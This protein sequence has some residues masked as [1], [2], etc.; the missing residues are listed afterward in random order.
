MNDVKSM[1]IVRFVL[2]E[3]LFL[4]IALLVYKCQIDD[5]FAKSINAGLKWAHKQNGEYELSAEKDSLLQ[6]IELEVP[7]LK[8]IRLSGRAENV[9]PDT[10]LDISFGGSNSQTEISIPVLGTFGESEEDLKIKFDESIGTSGKY[11]LSVR[12]RNPGSTKVFLV[13][14]SKPGIAVSFNQNPDDKTNVITGISYGQ[15]GKLSGL[16]FN[17]VCLLFLLVGY[18]CLGLEKKSMYQLFPIGMVILGICFQIIIPIG[19]APDESWHMDTA[20]KYS[21]MLLGIHDDTYLGTIHKRRCDVILADMLG[22]DVETGSYYQ[23]MQG[24]FKPADETDLIEVVYY[25]TSNQVPG[26]V[27]LPMALG[28]TI[29]RLLG[30][31][32]VTVYV[33][34]R[35]LAFAVYAALMYSAILLMPFGKN[36]LTLV[37]MLPI[38]LQ[39]GGSASYDSVIIGIGSVF[40]AM[41]LRSFDENYKAALWEKIVFV[42]TGLMLLMSKG[43]VYAPIVVLG[44]YFFFIRDNYSKLDNKKKTI[45]WIALSAFTI[46]MGI[47]VLYIFRDIFGFMFAEGNVT[48]YTRYTVTYF[49]HN[50]LDLLKIL[51]ATLFKRTDGYL[52]QFL[53]GE[54]GW[55][56]VE[57]SWFIV[58]PQFFIMILLTNAKGDA[59]KASRCEKLMA[60]VASGC[61]ILLVN[62]A[63]LLAFTDF[64]KKTVSGVQGRYFLPFAALMFLP[65]GGHIIN[66]SEADTKKLWKVSLFVEVVQMLQVLVIAWT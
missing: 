39:Q 4:T 5:S 25:D 27:F 22:N 24:M 13:A 35:I 15:I 38:S 57:L 32:A 63:M 6:E 43:G 23:L 60:L 37:A 41:T 14:N 47:V 64:G 45:F 46:V 3:L 34:G 62:I 49:A 8:Q 54:L 52:L 28:I 48:E 36:L 65:F 26:I 30:L 42:I 17:V 21:N 58:L 2:A 29:G 66:V 56:S 7:D 33:F 11:V 44:A 51:W 31:S 40:V 53:G 50:P 59:M 18:V 55:L 16:Y 1:K 9:N 10:M 19:G 61:S 20:Y 12:L